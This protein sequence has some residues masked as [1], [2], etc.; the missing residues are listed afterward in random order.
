VIKTIPFP[1]PVG[2]IEVVEFEADEFPWIT[3]KLKDGSVL[4]FK[5]FVTGVLKIGNDPNTGIPIY[6]IQTQG[7]IQLV[8]IPKEL[9][10][11]PSQS[12]ALSQTT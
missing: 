9:I 1:Q 8:K 2:E 10:K 7:A 6:S 3:I 5:V 11:K 4:R 12:R